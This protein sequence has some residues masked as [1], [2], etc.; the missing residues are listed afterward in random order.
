MSCWL[1]LTPHSAL[2]LVIA[3]IS[4]VGSFNLSSDRGV[5]G[6]AL[7]AKLFHLSSCAKFGKY[8]T[9]W[10]NQLAN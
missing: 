8:C 6:D 5:R 7:A 9:K 10:V 2:G 1:D 3:Y 4:V